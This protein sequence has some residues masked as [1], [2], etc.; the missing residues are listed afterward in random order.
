[1]ISVSRTIGLHA[2]PKKK[3]MRDVLGNCAP[4]LPAVDLQIKENTG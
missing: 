2:A 3:K 4:N 1:M